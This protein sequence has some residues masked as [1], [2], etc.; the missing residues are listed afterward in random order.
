M[1][2]LQLA[3]LACMAGFV[4]PALAVTIDGRIAPGEW[5]DARHV[6]DFRQTQP[7]TGKPAEYP[8]QAWVLA[9]P[10]IRA[11]TRS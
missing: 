8:V 3:A 11:M 5:R 6:T 2:L 10:P 1:R 7:L 4:A 9:T